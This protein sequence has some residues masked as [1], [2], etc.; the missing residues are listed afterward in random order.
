MHM[1][2][3]KIDLE[4]TRKKSKLF[5]LLEVQV[6]GKTTVISIIAK[7]IKKS[8]I[9][10][11]DFDFINN[12]LYS[13]FGVRKIPKE[14]K[15]WL[16]DEEFISEFKLNEKNIQNLIVKVDSN[17]DLISSSN[18]IFDD[19]YILN[20]QKINEALEELK[21]KYDI[22]L[23]DTSNDTKY[24]EITKAM[25]RVSNKIIC[26]VQ[27]NL[28]ETK[29]TMN[30]L[31]K[32]QEEKQKIKIIYNKKCKYTMNSKMLEVLFFKYKVIGTIDYDNKYNQII[33]KNVNQIYISNRI[34]KE[35]SKVAKKI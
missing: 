24:E 25:I 11:I 3:L 4:K 8:R 28:I 1:I 5:Q 32:I 23:I 7:F 26:L 9:L 15:E 18:V 27:G 19:K 20:Y 13:V 35:Y 29:K 34:R 16:Q 21:N 31:N 14:M 17:I 22:I 6:L 2:K 12:N 10:I 30:I 33:N